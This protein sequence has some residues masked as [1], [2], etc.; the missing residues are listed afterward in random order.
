MTLLADQL[1]VIVRIGTGV[2]EELASRMGV[3]QE[4]VSA[5]ERAEPGATEVRTLAGYVEALGG[6]LEILADFGG[7][8]IVLR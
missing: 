4:R 3:R 6:R 2:G 7:E 5:I 1:A 8:L